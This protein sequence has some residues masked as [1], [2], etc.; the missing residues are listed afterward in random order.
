MMKWFNYLYDVGMDNLLKIM[1]T[2]WG[3]ILRMD[4]ASVPAGWDTDKWLY[5]AKVNK[6][7]VVDSF[8]EGNKGASMG[9]LS[10]LMNNQSSGVI[11]AN[12]GDAIQHYVNMLEWIGETMS[13]MVGISKQREGAI[14]NRETVG[15][16][17]RSVLQS[18]HITE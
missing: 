1:A 15:G 10:G 7:A 12:Q 5:Y 17:E 13:N 8:K 18:S 2:N 4:F 16:V 9:K 6:I 3:K 11:D 14:D